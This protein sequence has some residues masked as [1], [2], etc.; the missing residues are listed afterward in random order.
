MKKVARENTVQLEALPCLFMKVARAQKCNSRG[1]P[2]PSTPYD[3]PASPYCLLLLL[4]CLPL[5]LTF[6]QAVYKCSY[7]G[8]LC[9]MKKLYMKSNQIYLV[10]LGIDSFM[11]PQNN[12]FLHKVIFQS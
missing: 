12:E 10:K 1:K 5:H 2:R 8:Y 4:P 7:V 9:Y 11:F 6:L 3:S